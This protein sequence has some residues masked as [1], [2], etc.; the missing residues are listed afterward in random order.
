[1]MLE[2]NLVL[3]GFI[4]A[5]IGLSSN[6]LIDALAGVDEGRRPD[7]QSNFYGVLESRRSQL[8][9]DL[10]KL[11][12]YDLNILSH[13]AAIARYRSGFRLKYFQYLAA[14]ATE[15][16]F[17]RFTRDPAALLVALNDYRAAHFSLL[18]AYQPQDLRKL[19]FF[20]ATGAGKTLLLHLNLRQFLEYRPFEPENVLLIAPTETLARQHLHELS[21][22]GIPAS[23]ALE[24]GMVSGDVQVI[25]ITKLYVDSGT[26]GARGGVSIPTSQFG[27][28]NLILVDEGHKGSATKSEKDT[29][30]AWRDIREALVRDGG[31]TLEYSATFAQ[32]TD[33]DETLLAEYARSILFE[34]AYRR[35]HSDRYGKDYR[36]INVSRHE[37]LYGDTLLLGGLLT[38]YEKR[39]YYDDQKGAL[40]PYLLEPPLFVFVGAQVTAGPEVLSIVRF[41]DRVLRYEAWTIGEIGKLLQG[42]SGLP[43]AAGGD[44]FANQFRYLKELQLSP[45]AL[46]TDLRRRLLRGVG[47]LSLHLLRRGDGEIGLRTA[48]SAQ[49]AYC[50]VINVGDPREF[51]KKV[52]AETTIAIGEEDHIRDSL[53]DAINTA[54]S[55]LNF[56]IGSK[57]FIEGWSSW[58][59]S[60]MGLLKV[61][62]NAGAQVLQLFGRGVR[63][64]GMGM[65]LKRSEAVPGVHPP[66]V[67][68]LET[69]HIFGVKADYLDKFEASLRREGLEAP[70]IRLL[71]L[72][73]KDDVLAREELLGLELPPTYSFA[74]RVISFDPSVVKVSLDLNP[75]VVTVDAQETAGATARHAAQD[76]PAATQDLLPYEA[77]FTH[78]LRYKM[79][80]NWQNLYISRA[81]VRQFFAAS[82]ELAAPPSILQPE[83]PE[84][85]V[86]LEEAARSLLEAGLDR[87]FYLR[88]Q[89]TDTVNLRTSIIRES[90][91]NFPTAKDEAGATVYA[92]EL[93]IPPGMLADVEQLIGDAALR[94]TEDLPNAV[95]GATPKLPRMY[96]DLH[97]YNPLTI[98]AGA[99]KSVPTGLVPSEQR[100]AEQLRTFWEQAVLDAAWNGC[101][102]YLLRNQ[103]KK[104]IGFF[105][106]AGFYPDFLLWM[107]RGARQALAFVDPKGLLRWEEEKV[108]L[109]AYIR[110]LSGTLGLPTLAFI[111]SPTPLDA[112]SIPGV[113]A[114]G[115]L[116]YLR[117]RH[118]WGQSDPAY[119]EAILT[120]LRGAVT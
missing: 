91:P 43:S 49:D 50:G 61:G 120:E 80:K 35:F 4:S 114:S 53:F 94:V 63:L 12:R 95:T 5:Q 28:R 112:I 7:G 68:L 98:Q 1:M 100:F 74:E 109:L 60:V 51:L 23:H 103:P 71:P 3:V 110:S 17:D 20:M 65:G 108:E 87:Y 118:V 26:T 86:A 85:M 10:D 11:K 54:E 106:T 117:G 96:V 115:T 97:L 32:V 33:T 102:I 27:G 92:Y 45:E 48:D 9:L 107:K 64:K 46:Y 75:R 24:A 73:V 66:Y 21:A 59:V 13:E 29:E 77:L 57:K 14:L 62:K 83:R 81:A 84:H 6:A 42:Q 52:Q 16:Y 79:Q 22:S 104:G 72:E 88:Q 105:Q 56:L 2:Q 44:V 90:H 67:G 41:L 47:R 37:E 93:K 113:A 19:A 8:A 38:F 58:R 40:A 39:R 101:T 55:P 111:V 31:F 69:L 15:I 30:R 78:A 119:I 70:L 18:P 116:A 89:Q 25:E 99:V 34:Y 82:V 76:L 36:I